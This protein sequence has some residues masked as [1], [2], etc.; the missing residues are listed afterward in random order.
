MIGCVIDESEYLLH[1]EEI[2]EEVGFSNV[3]LVGLYSD[4]D[5]RCFYY[6]DSN[7]KEI[8][9]VFPIKRSGECE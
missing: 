3:R 7:T 8:L 4:H 5:E 6:V 2:G 9:D 1:A